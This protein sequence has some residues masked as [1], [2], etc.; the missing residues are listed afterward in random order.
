MN[1]PIAKIE[2]AKNGFEVE[3][4]DPEIKKKNMESDDGYK[5]PYV[6]FVFKTADEV[7]EFLKENLDKAV[8]MDDYATSFDEAVKE[9]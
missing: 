3:M 6:N 5:D 1:G 8:P 7:M 4:C 9:D 2:R